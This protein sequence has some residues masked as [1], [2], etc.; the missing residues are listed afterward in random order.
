MGRKT[1][2][3]LKSAFT[4]GATPE[5]KDFV[6]V[7]DSFKHQDDPAANIDT[8]SQP[9]AEAGDDNT[10]LMT[11]LR[12]KQAIEAIARLANLIDLSNEVNGRIDTAINNLIGSAPSTLNTLEEIA[13]ALGDDS[14]AYNSLMAAINNRYTK[15]QI[16]GKF[17]GESVGKKQVHWHRVTGKPPT[18]GPSAH[19]HTPS[20]VGLGNLPNAKSDFF[21]NDS[22]S[23]ATSK[24]V[25]G[26]YSRIPYRLKSGSY[27]GSGI[28]AVGRDATITHN[29]N[30]NTGQYRIL[31]TPQWTSPSNSPL[32][33]RINVTMS[34]LTANGFSVRIKVLPDGTANP[35]PLPSAGVGVTVHYLI[36]Y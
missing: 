27:N 25:Y 29:L 24:A 6:D 19:A 2:E 23:L 20:Q 4:T 26:L 15:A 10:K 33:W 13:T 17:E 9:E 5:Q 16:D 18:F 7:F 31:L 28:R 34:N 32:G 35:L 8:A 21:L 14:N 36:I 1:R 30:L 3:Q 11:P 12:T 22:N